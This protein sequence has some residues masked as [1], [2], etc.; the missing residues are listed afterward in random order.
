MLE[1]L[2]IVVGVLAVAGFL[3]ASLLF[4]GEYLTDEQSNDYLLRKA[5]MAKNA[6]P[7]ARCYNSVNH[8][9]VLLDDVELDIKSYHYHDPSITSERLNKI[10]KRFLENVKK[11]CNKTLT[12]YEDAYKDALEIQ[13]T[14]NSLQGAW[15]TFLVG[16]SKN[17]IASEDLSSYTPDNARLSLFF[18]EYVFTRDDVQEFYDKEL[19]L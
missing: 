13:K 6:E 16:G 7:Y 17:E 10:G 5:Y 3:I 2:G 14:A 9:Q 8:G 1:K 18:T 4:P 15:W 11:Q 19:G 12:D